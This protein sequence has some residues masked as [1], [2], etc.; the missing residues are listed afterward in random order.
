MFLVENLSGTEITKTDMDISFES[1]GGNIQV[2]VGSG[3][4]NKNGEDILL[5]EVKRNIISPVSL[6][7]VNFMILLCKKVVSGDVEIVILKSTEVS[8][9]YPSL[10]SH[11]YD[12]VEV[13]AEGVIPAGSN[14]TENLRGKI[15]HWV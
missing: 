8:R 6:Y 12:L 5:S 10:G 1:I 15:Y 3:A 13:L 2:V 14:L 4:M 11:G 7:D 9:G